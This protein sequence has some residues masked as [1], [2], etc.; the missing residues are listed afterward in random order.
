MHFKQVE[1]KKKGYEAWNEPSIWGRFAFN[2]VVVVVL[3]G[4]GKREDIATEEKEEIR[5]ISFE[6]VKSEEALVKDEFEMRMHPCENRYLYQ[7]QSHCYSR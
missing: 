7:A 2:T 3:A 4:T 1:G 6:C 5:D